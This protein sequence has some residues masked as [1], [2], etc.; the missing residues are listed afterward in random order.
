MNK[1]KIFALGGLN[2][3]GKNMYVV[4]VNKDIFVFDAGLKYDN[5]INLGI[6]YIIPNIDY[7]VKNRKRIKG[8][9]LT[10]GHDGNIGATPDVLERIPELPVYGTKL[11]LELLKKDLYKGQIGKVNLIEIKP[12]VKINFGRNSIFPIS[13]TH[14]I[15]DSV[16][17]VLYTPDG[18]IVYTGDFVFDST[19]QGA[20]KT[21]IG[22]LAY[23]GK[24]GVLCLLSE[25]FYADRPGH[26]SPNNRISDF[27]REVLSETDDRIIATVMPA[28]YYRIQEIFNEINNTHRKVVIMGKALQDTINYAMKEGYLDINP[29]KIGTLA[30]LE[31][32]NTLVLISDNKEKPFANLNRI[33]NGFDKFIHIKDTDTIFIT[34]PSYPGI[35][36]RLALIMDEIAMLGAD[37]VSLSSKKHLLHHSSREDLML[38]INLMSPKYYFPVKGEY[39]NQYENGEI[40]EELGIPKE[41]IILKLNGDV[42]EMDNGENIN[43]LEHIETDDVLIDGNSQGDIGDLVLKDREMLGEN[44][45]VIIS[46]TLDKNTKEIV[47]GPEILTR[48]FVYVKE[49]Q[50][51]LEETKQVSREVIES[52]IE[53]N[54]KRVDYSKIKNDVR[55]V[56]GKFFYKETESKPMIITVIQ[57]V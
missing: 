45:I 48:G 29:D 9:F 12:H 35:E 32:K 49:S 52:D 20:Y 42:F 22:K 25:S 7:L 46:C 10:H 21:D 4:E 43:S 5:D 37:A 17:Y 41:N 16:C 54:S 15:P 1:I 26:T 11:T 57:E 38:M 33:I 23:V 36:K 47:G 13:V 14:S 28:H 44:G 24:Q 31:G 19:M 50:D 51:L 8:L 3:N 53:L 6:D 56:L 39:K 30:D 18:A 55:E 2:E 27:I 34:E 40:A